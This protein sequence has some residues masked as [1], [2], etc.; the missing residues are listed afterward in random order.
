MAKKKSVRKKVTKKHN[1]P[2][3]S[4]TEQAISL[5]AENDK[6]RGN[7]C[8]IAMIHHTEEEF[9]MDFILAIA[10]SH[11]LVSRVITNPKHMKRIHDAI[12]ENIERYEKKFGKIK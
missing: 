8:N 2:E 4:T 6:L 1:A 7:Y 3:K 12:G 9:A 5:I 10:N 11:S